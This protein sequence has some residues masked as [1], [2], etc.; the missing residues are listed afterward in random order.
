MKYRFFAVVLAFLACSIGQSAQADTLDTLKPDHPRVLAHADDFKRIAELVKTDPLA[1]RWYGEFKEISEGLFDQPV[2]QYDLRD[3]R[4]LL[5]ESN[6]VLRRVK[7]LAMLYKIEGGQR[8]LDRIWA[9]LQAAANFKDWNPDHFLD[10]SVMAA[11]FAIAYDWLY[12]DWSDAQRATIRD[13]IIRHGI[14]PGLLAYEQKSWWTRTK[15]NWNQVCNGGLI[16]AA[17]AIADDEPELAAQLI[18]KAVASLPIS[19]KRYAPDGGYDEGPGY[20]G[21]GTSYNVLAIASLQSALG[22]D[23][24]LG[25]APGFDVTAGFPMQMT[26]P[27]GMA[28]NF[29]DGKAKTPRSPIMFY[30]AKRYDQPGYARFAAEHNRGGA[31]DLLWYDPTIVAQDAQAM[32][33]ATVF[34]SADVGAMRS[35]WH[36]PNAWYVGLKGGAIDHGH[37]QMDLGSFILE[38]QGVRWLIDLGGD[39]YNL[40][41][42][43]D[44]GAGRWRYYRNR[45]E[46]HNTL[47][48]N[49]DKSGGQHRDA[50]AEVTLVG[51]TLEVDLSQAYDAKA[52][53]TIQLDAEQDAVRL[54]D[55]VRLDEPGDIWWFAHTRAQITLSA[56]KRSAILEQDGKTI[57]ASIVTPKLAQF[58]IM[59][60]RPLATSPNPDGQNPNNGAVI[61]NS[62]PKA[63]FV[64]RGETPIYGE[65]EPS[66]TIRKLAIQIENDTFARIEV[67]FEN[68]D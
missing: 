37:A 21:F 56:D 48:I 57:R 5:Y 46:G 63:H 16:M 41:G 53:R 11:A 54:V 9:D 1:N 49:P 29:G 67:V 45:A 8:Y 15:I 60:A 19:M 22:H 32:P 34:H 38:S 40:P 39:D 17:L 47:L 44:P 64:L 33:L 59:D 14:E 61:K 25:E 65:P 6:D 43:F 26:G 35:N 24:K 51:N 7:S 58:Q 28:Y 12:D 10:V 20:W 36:D 42:Y 2:A 31:L 55:K 3:G 62:S 23:F 13:A 68:A 52:K 27:T 30:F 4:R 18:D 50:N 66:E